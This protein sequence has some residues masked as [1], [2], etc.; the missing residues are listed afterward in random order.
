MASSIQKRFLRQCGVPAFSRRP[1]FARSGTIHCVKSPN[2]VSVWLPL[3]RTSEAPA[4]ATRKNSQ[5]PA[6]RTIVLE[7][8]IS[9]GKAIL[10]GRSAEGGAAFS[11]PYVSINE[12]ASRHRWL[13]H[14]SG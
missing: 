14:R 7:E 3:G 8:D 5:I 12:A 6:M 9:S 11:T 2:A 10:E 13:A 4:Y 1:A